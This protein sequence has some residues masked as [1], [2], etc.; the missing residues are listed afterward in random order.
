MLLVICCWICVKIVVGTPRLFAFAC[1]AA[2]PCA[3]A[4]CGEAPRLMAA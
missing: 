4:C 1:A 2:T 3:F